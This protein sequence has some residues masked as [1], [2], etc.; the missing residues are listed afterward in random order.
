[1]NN[2]ET[3]TKTETA[4][5][6]KNFKKVKYGSMS[7]AV[8]V[9]VIV[10]VVILNLIAGYA[11]KRAPLKI[12]LTADNRYE[13]SDESID[14]LRNKLDKDVE[15]IITCPKAEFE[16]LSASAEFF[17]LYNYGIKLDCPYDMIPVL[18]EKYEMYANQGKGKLSV[19]YVDL[20]KNPKAGK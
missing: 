11:S 12:D 16:E 9:L 4:K 1:M 20:D 13:L 17:Y 5:K 7:I 6:P 15:V 2:P 8:M 3:Q 10:L 19:R 18:L 14:F